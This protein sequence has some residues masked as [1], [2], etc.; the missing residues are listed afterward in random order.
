MVA[1]S[2]AVASAGAAARLHSEF[3]DGAVDE[4]VLRTSPLRRLIAESWQRSRA[5]GVN[6][7]GEAPSGPGRSTRSA[8]ATR[9]PA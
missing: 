1:G 5:R 2:P 3:V 8:P 4:T 9:S 7:D 6:P